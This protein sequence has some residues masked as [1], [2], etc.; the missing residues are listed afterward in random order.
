MPVREREKIQEMLWGERP[1]E[2][3]KEAGMVT[4][5]RGEIEDRL[6]RLEKVGDYL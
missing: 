6:R 4:D 3:G 1:V 2:E 5:F